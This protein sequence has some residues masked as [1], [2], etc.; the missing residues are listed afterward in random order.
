LFSGVYF[1]CPL[2]TD[3]VLTKEEWKVKIKEFLFEQ[4]EEERGLTA[5]L[6]IQSCNYNRIKVKECVDILCRYLDN[7]IANPQ[8][9]KFHKI[10][11]SNATFRDKVLPILGATDLL[12]A[13][14]FQQE[15]LDHNG[16]N[17]EFW[18]FKE[19]NIEGFQALEVI[20]EFIDIVILR[21]SRF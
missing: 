7:I 12:L 11:C 15:V 14:G 21:Q 13:A 6:I 18:V 10:R 5:C 4:L 9:T 20:N 3:E 2:I 1:R 17:E 19:Q 8:E 16:T